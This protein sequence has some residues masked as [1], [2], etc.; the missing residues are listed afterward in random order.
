MAI[1]RFA[2]GVGERWLTSTWDSLRLLTPNWMSRLP[3]W[4]YTGAQPEGFMSAVEVADFLEA[5]SRSF[6]ALVQNHTRVQRVRPSVPPF[7]TR[8]DPRVEQLAP[9]EYRRSGQ[10]AAGGVLIVGAS[11][12]G[13]QLAD[14]LRRARREVYLALVRTHT[15][16]AALAR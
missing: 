15:Q 16:A 7:A 9:A 2:I 4:A 3:H 10:V 14:E 5:Y 12:T 6:A 8:L 1:P 13:V 11:A